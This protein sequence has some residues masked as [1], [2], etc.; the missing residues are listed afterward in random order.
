[1]RGRT[2]FGAGPLRGDVAV[3][4]DKSI[5]HRALIAAACANVP[6]VVTNLNPGRDV[7]ATIE[8]LQALG[9]TVKPEAQSVRVISAG[10]RPPPAPLDCANSGST[11]R[12]LLGA[13]A[14]ANV[15]ACFD[16]D[17][18]LRHRPMEP[19]A[20]QLRAFGARIDTTDGLLP[21]NL[22]GTPEIQTR[23]FILLAPSAQVKTALLFAGAF[24]G[25][26]IT[27]AGDRG[28]RDHT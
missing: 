10:L 3:P 9:V 11:V 26:A 28:S 8:A 2:N 5:S 1:M 27:I 12:M 18:S 14:G 21:M 20:A 16:G 25:V 13:C 24:A 6:M 15:P 4:G 7:R 22:W 19:V 17:E 23:N